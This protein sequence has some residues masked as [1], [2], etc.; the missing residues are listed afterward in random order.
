MPN[1]NGGEMTADL[2]LGRWQDVLGDVDE[3]DAVIFDAPYSVRQHE[4]YVSG[5]EMKAEQL[6]RKRGAAAKRRLLA[7]P[8]GGDAPSGRISM[9]GVS[10]APVDEPGCFEFVRRWAPATRSWF[11]VFGDHLTQA[12]WSAA[13]ANAGWY[14]FAPVIWV[15]ADPSPRFQ[16]D[17]PASACEYITVARPKRKTTCG[18]LPGYY[19]GKIAK[20][21]GPEGKIVTGQKPMWLMRALIRDYS[22]PGDLVCDPFAGGGTTLLAALTE[23]RRA[24]GAEMDA[25][26]HAKAV[27]RLEAYTPDMFA[28]LEPVT[29]TQGGLEL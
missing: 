15:K 3:V 14:V 13:L 9:G 27:R 22:R 26:T 2:R 29:G 1:D 28:R 23:G 6:R 11:V 19:Y 10:Y 5:S 21:N 24:I 7:R 4:G 16:G 18:S 17:G 8:S 12:W 20:A 25:E